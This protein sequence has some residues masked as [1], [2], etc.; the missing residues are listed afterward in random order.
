MMK[1]LVILP[2]GS[3]LIELE[4]LISTI[5]PLFVISYDYNKY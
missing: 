1:I 3:D 5:N 4:Y 2:S